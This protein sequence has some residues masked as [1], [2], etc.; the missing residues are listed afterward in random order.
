MNIYLL[1]VIVVLVVLFLIFI[2][3][4]V[5]KKMKKTKATPTNDINPEVAAFFENIPA[6]ALENTVVE[7]DND[8]PTMVLPVQEV[9]NAAQGIEPINLGEE[10]KP[11]EEIPVS[12]VVNSDNGE[13][14]VVDSNPLG[15]NSTETSEPNLEPFINGNTVNENVQGN[16]VQNTF[17]Q[18]L[19][20]DQIPSNRFINSVGTNV[21]TVE[22]M[23]SPDV[24]SKDVLQFDMPT[25]EEKFL[26]QDQ[27]VIE[28]P[29][30]PTIE[31]R[32]EEPDLSNRNN[33]S[34]DDLWKF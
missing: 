6:S 29:I 31:E 16:V 10:N 22:P 25:V 27:T 20:N 8:M 18:P 5:D 21:P 13:Q 12:S 7:L 33:V 28:E 3:Y 23:G 30:V 32:E 24:F 2:G 19:S 1:L 26:E 34:D 14:P 9:A 17:E 4:L 15:G 11:I